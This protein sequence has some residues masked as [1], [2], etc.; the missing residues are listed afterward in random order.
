L[1]AHAKKVL[2]GIVGGV[3]LL[4]GIAM[5]V[6]PG[7]AF[8]VIPAGLAILATEFEWAERWKDRV[9]DKYH[10]MREEHRRKKRERASAY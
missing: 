4:A 2:I 9:K 10:Q 3:V 1:K 6:L 7:P 8:L 5:M